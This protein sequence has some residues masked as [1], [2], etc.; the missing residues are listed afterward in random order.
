MADNQNK[1][2]SL[3][4]GL[5][6]EG[7]S[8]TL[9][10]F[11]QLSRDEQVNAV[12]KTGNDL[13]SRLAQ[14][15]MQTEQIKNNHIRQN[16]SLVISDFVDEIDKTLDSAG[17]DPLGA[18]THLILL[19]VEFVFRVSELIW[20][21]IYG[22]LQNMFFPSGPVSY[23][24]AQA[25]AMEF[26]TL[27]GDLN[28]LATIFDL[29]GDIEILGTKLPGKALGRFVSN[30]SWTFGLGWMTWVVMS[31]ILRASISDPIQTE[32]NKITRSRN[33]TSTEIR[34]LYEYGIDKLEEH[35][36]HL[37]ELGYSDDKIEKLIDMMK[38]IVLKSEARSWVT[39]MI[40]SYV[41]G[42]ITDDELMK[43]I[44]MAYWTNEEQNFKFWQGKVR[45]ETEIIDLRVDE[46]EKAFKSGK[47]DENEARARLS[48]FIVD[49]RMVEAYI[50]LWKQYRKPEELV[51]P[52]ETANYKL[53][54]LK[55]RIEG[56]EKQIM[57]LE[58][59]MKQQLDVYD[60]EI[61]E[62]RTRLEARIAAAKEEFAAYANKTAAEI[63]SRIIYYESLIPAAT[64]LTKLRYQAAEELL[65]ALAQ[66]RVEER[67]AKLN[68][69]IE[70]WTKE[71]EAKIKV[72]QEK[73]EKYKADMERRI[74]ELK[75]KLEEY[76]LEAT[77]TEKVIEKLEAGA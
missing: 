10:T 70:R 30:I 17:K 76:E 49:P 35:V 28:V 6:F 47:I 45:K 8:E 4:G 38:R 58:V 20:G 14:I 61:E 46:I 1:K 53:Q 24:E 64:G 74:D 11:Q 23:K 15:Q 66:A 50:A 54:R 39:Y 51:D 9:K 59:V 63:Q 69:L 68:A 37:A 72:I 31:P 5:I 7:M 48:E 22:W 13:K 34:E 18:F 41:K 40:Q 12:N 33:W 77:A 56:L 32:M 27:V 16:M 19:P 62:L 36:E 73:K 67:A 26:F 60:A 71:T 55:I 21:A 3:L 43:A 65:Q 2:M 44:T 52:L 29:V 42:Y 75:S 57:H 25:N